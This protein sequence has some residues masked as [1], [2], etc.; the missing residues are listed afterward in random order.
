[1]KIAI[2]WA[3]T[4]TRLALVFLIEAE[5]GRALSRAKANR[6][7]EEAWSWARTWRSRTNMSR[8]IIATAPLGEMAL[9]RTKPWMSISILWAGFDD[10]HKG[11][12]V[13]W[14]I[15]SV[16]RTDWQEQQNDGLVVSF[17]RSWRLE[18]SRYMQAHMSVMSAETCRLYGV[19]VPESSSPSWHSEHS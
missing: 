3:M 12:M 16:F 18:S 10:T 2:Q 8:T 19:Y 5:K 1:M 17:V 9:E 7:R 4:G 14:N 6:N 15:G 13:I 11:E